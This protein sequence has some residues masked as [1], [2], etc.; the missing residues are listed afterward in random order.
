MKRFAIILTVLVLGIATVPALAQ[1]YTPSKDAV[2][3]AHDKTEYSPYAGREYPT[4]VHWGDTHLHTAVSVDAGTMCTVGQE[5]AFRFARVRRLSRP[6]DCMRSSRDRW[7]GSPSG[8]FRDVRAD[9]PAPPGDPKYLG[10]EIGKR[11]FDGLTSGDPSTT[12]AVAMETSFVV[13]TGPPIASDKESRM[14]GTPARPWRAGRRAWPFHGVDRDEWTARGGDNEHRN[15]ILRGDASAA[16]QT[17]LDRNHSQ[18]PEHLR[19][20]LEISRRAAV[21]TSRHP[22]HATSATACRST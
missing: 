21:P 20:F 19:V 2:A 14:P 18:N 22:A 3:G 12:F 13:P 8:P 7:T 17:V 11:W 10:T 5:D 16:N 9:A 1:E 4:N 6:T 15:V